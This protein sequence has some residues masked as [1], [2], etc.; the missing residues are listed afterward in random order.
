MEEKSRLLRTKNFRNFRAQR[1]ISLTWI[2]SSKGASLRRIRVKTIRNAV[3]RRQEV[4][5]QKRISP[6]RSRPAQYSHI[7]TFCCLRMV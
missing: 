7:L 5:E 4:I 6:Q 2:P 3:R 1:S